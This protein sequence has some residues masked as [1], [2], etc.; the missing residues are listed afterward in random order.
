MFALALPDK[1][2][3]RI[4]A[5]AYERFLTDKSSVG[6]YLEGGINAS[7]WSCVE[8]DEFRAMCRELFA[9]KEEKQKVKQ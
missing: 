9:P 6:Y 1:E 3:E 2:R 7:S 4:K 8:E 5:A